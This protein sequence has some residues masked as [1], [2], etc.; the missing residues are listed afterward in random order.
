MPGCVFRARR[1]IRGMGH[2]LFPRYIQR[3]ARDFFYLTSR[4]ILP[5][6]PIAP[7]AGATPDPGRGAVAHARAAA[8]RLPVRARDDLGLTRR[9]S[10]AG[11]ASCASSAPIRGAHDVQPPPSG[12]ATTPRS[13]PRAPA[14]CDGATRTLWWRGGVFS[15]DASGARPRAPTRSLGGAPPPSRARPARARRVGVQDEDGM[16]VWVELPP[17]AG[18]DARPPPR[19]GRAARALGCSAPHGVPGTRARSSAA[20]STLRATRLPPA[21]RRRAHCTRLVRAPRARRPPDLPRH[22]DRAHPGVAAT[23]E[24]KRVRY[25]YKPAA[26]A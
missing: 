19:D 5:G 26:Q 24:A 16:L 9:A 4:S 8:A 20:P 7:A 14:R 22:A 13:W 10:R 11:A 21:V 1:M 3:E 18:P 6:A 25:F 15:V 17:D 2:M 23:P 12:A